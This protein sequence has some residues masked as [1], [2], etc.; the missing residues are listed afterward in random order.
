MRD[1]LAKIRESCTLVFC[2]L[3]SGKTLDSKAQSQYVY[4][5]SLYPPKL[6]SVCNILF[7]N[8]V[9]GICKRQISTFTFIN[10]ANEEEFLNNQAEHIEYHF[11]NSIEWSPM[12]NFF[13]ERLCAA[14]F[15]WFFI[16]GV[17]ALFN[18][19]YVPCVSSLLKRN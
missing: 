15:H 12:R 16:Q 9:H 5:I 18:G 1:F 8:A 3:W 11:Q 14:E 13:F 17:D 2:A 19:L 6:L 10:K 7:I 4:A